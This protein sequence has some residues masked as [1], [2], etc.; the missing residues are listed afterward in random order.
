LPEGAAGVFPSVG[1]GCAFFIGT[2]ISK[3]LPA[4]ATGFPAQYK[5][6]C[7]P[8]AEDINPGDFIRNHPDAGYIHE[9]CW[10]D[11]DST[12]QSN[13]AGFDAFTRGRAPGIAV[14]PRGTTG[15]DKC[16]KCFIVHSPGQEGCE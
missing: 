6:L 7:L 15:K 10:D 16:M 4:M 9:E 2:T 13:G 11:V 14:L 8:C 1:I 3:G 12:P 5:G